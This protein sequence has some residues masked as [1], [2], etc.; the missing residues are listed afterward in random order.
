MLSCL[1][2]YSWLLAG[3]ILIVPPPGPERPVREW[4]HVMAY[5][6]AVQCEGSLAEFR[7]DPRIDPRYKRVRC[8]PAD[9]IYPP[10]GG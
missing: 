2:R 4:E 8:V 7:D 5:D 6:T 9:F 10:T 1:V 3:W